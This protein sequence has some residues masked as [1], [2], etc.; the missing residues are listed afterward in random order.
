MAGSSSCPDRHLSVFLSRELE[1]ITQRSEQLQEPNEMPESSGCMS[2]VA[3]LDTLWLQ[4]ARGDTMPGQSESRPM[5]DIA[6]EPQREAHELLAG[7]R[8]GDD[9]SYEALVRGHGGRMLSVALR[10]LGNPEDA[11]DCVQEAFLQAFK[12]VDRFEGRSSVGTWLHRIVVNS[13]L[14]KLRSRRRHPEG[15]LDELMP[16]FDEYQCRLEPRGQ[17]EESVETLASRKETRA[18]VREAIDRLPYDYRTVLLLRD[19]EELDTRETAKALQIEPGAVKTRL[20]RA[21]AALKKL[22]EGAAFQGLVP[23]ESP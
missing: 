9:A 12:Y 4:T 18:A 5:S 17:G 11:R 6:D 20:H 23:R 1:A 19:L 21:R 8:A 3:F 7:L 16:Q 22:L 10:I 15:S 2:S 14:Q 13:A